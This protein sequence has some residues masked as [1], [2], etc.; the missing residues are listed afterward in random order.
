M[1]IV[2]FTKNNIS[3]NPT[4]IFEMAISKGVV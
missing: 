4:K 1:Q 3:E 2:F